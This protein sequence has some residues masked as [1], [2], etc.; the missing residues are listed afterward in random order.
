MPLDNINDD[1]LLRCLCHAALSNAPNQHFTT[2]G[3]SFDIFPLCRQYTFFSSENTINRKSKV[4]GIVCIR[5]R[6]HL[7]SYLQKQKEKQKRENV[8]EKFTR[9][10]KDET[11]N[12]RSS[13]ANFAEVKE[14]WSVP[15]TIQINE[16]LTKLMGNVMREDSDD[17]DF[18]KFCDKF[19]PEG[20]IS[21]IRSQSLQY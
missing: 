12:K 1:N 2:N 3:K 5:F 18:R 16:R 11:L 20:L 7:S 8:F 15:L 19:T 13:F 6:W 9:V 4:I 21:R 14:V 10:A 17:A